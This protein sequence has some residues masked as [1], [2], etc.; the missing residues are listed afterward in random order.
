MSLT[1]RRYSWAGHRHLFSARA[2]SKGGWGCPWA[3]PESMRGGQGRQGEEGNENRRLWDSGL[4]PSLGPL[5]CLCQVQLPRAGLARQEAAATHTGLAFLAF[6]SDL[7]ASS[8]AFRFS[9]NLLAYEEKEGKSS[10][11]GG[12]EQGRRLPP[13]STRGH[14]LKAELPEKLTDN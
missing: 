7:T 3:Q 5:A 11:D 14:T 10:C 13:S 4:P 12:S 9:A 2:P 8:W 1:S 6:F